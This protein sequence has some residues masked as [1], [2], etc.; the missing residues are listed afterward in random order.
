MV[1]SYPLLIR[2]AT[3]DDLPQLVHLLR[4]CVTAMQRDGIDQWDD[5]YPTGEVL[6][7]DIE[8]GT[9]YVASH[10]SV[11]VVGAVVLD[12]HQAPQYSEVPW[13]IAGGKV[14]VVHRLMVHPDFQREG[15]ARF[16]M[17]FIEGRAFELGFGVIRLDTFTQNP[18]AL[19]LYQGLGYRDAGPVTLRKG[20]FRCF[21]K[22]L[23]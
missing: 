5:I 15:I 21:E 13:T 20:L 6:G 19:R 2:P 10:D 17:E 22:A 9:I 4:E 18:R 8:G 14:G 12:E 16:L 11:P 23:G 7:A 1:S 3:V